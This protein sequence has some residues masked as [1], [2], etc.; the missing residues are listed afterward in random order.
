[1]ESKYFIEGDAHARG[2]KKKQFY[3][4]ES[5]CAAAMQLAL[6]RSHLAN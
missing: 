4:V 2:G 6:Y 3:F 1:M 5:L